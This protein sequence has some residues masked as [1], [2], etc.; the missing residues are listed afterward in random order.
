[1]FRVDNIDKKIVFTNGCFDILHVGHIRYM[2]EAA[3]LGDI[4]VVGLNS[5]VSVKRLKGS[6]RP[7]NN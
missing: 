1:M 7:V 3:K 2:H 5:D 4:L 6:E